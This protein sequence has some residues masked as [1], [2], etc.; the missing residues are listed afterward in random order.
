MLCNTPIV[1]AAAG[2]VV[3]L[4]EHGKTGWLSPP[5]DALKLS[6]IIQQCQS[7]PEQEIAHQAR[8]SASER[9]NLETT[10]QQIAQLLHQVVSDRG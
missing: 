9:F 6:G 1:A 8:Q 10:N 5:G 4:I 7:Q 2:G 3:E